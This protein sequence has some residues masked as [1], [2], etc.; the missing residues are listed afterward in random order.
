LYRWKLAYFPPRLDPALT[1][2]ANRC[3]PTLVSRR[4]GLTRTVVA[5]VVSAL[6]FAVYVVFIRGFNRRRVRP[7]R[8]GLH[9][10]Q[11]S[12]LSQRRIAARATS[13]L[14]PTCCVDRTPET[15]ELPP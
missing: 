7:T 9:G 10:D 6:S 8:R 15:T 2:S 14:S 1:R 13:T 5:V 11:P 12:S 3:E 4:I